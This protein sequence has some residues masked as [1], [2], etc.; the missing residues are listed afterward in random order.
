MLQ[1]SQL[2]YYQSYIKKVNLPQSS[3]YK[4][5]YLSKHNKVRLFFNI[6][7]KENSNKKSLCRLRFFNLRKE[8]IFNTD[9][10]LN[11]KE[12]LINQIVYNQMK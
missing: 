2:I 12:E 6:A 11:R 5:L 7:K 1:K 3:V 8:F 9:R 4:E 10:I